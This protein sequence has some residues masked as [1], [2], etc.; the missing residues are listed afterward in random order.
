MRKRFEAVMNVPAPYR[1]HLFNELWRQLSAK[2]I[3]FHVHYM[4]RGFKARPDS[5]MNPKIDFPHTYWRNFGTSEHQFNPGMIAHIMSN[6]PDW[7]ICGSSFYTPTG[8][9]VMN[10]CTD[11]MRIAWVEGNTKTTGEMHGIKGWIKRWVLSKCKLVA[12][13][14]SDAKKY[15][16]LHQKLTKRKMPKAIFLPNLVDETR[17]VPRAEIDEVEIER[18]RKYMGVAMN[19]KVC[20]IPAR[21]TEVKGLVPFVSLLDSVMLEGWKIVILGKGELKQKILDKAYE[22][23][24]AD[25]VLIC[26]YVAYED[27][28]RFYA[29]ADLLLMPSVYDP[30]PLSVIEALHAGLPVA[31]TQQAGN[32]EEAVTEGENGWVLPV[33]DQEAFAAKLKVVFAADKATLKQMGE[34]SKR[35][36]SRFWDTKESIARFVENV[37]HNLI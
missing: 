6:Q 37:T 24:V 11:A 9:A 1:Q 4:A 28:P 32:V 33:L 18:A 30:N 10:W 34:V 22:R 23:G 3:D 27:M 25:R 31:V 36:N 19:D 14:G 16:E 2:G 15:I 12:V 20:F 26:D 13:P 35:E 7:I 17:F 8:I 21:L 5:W 29:A